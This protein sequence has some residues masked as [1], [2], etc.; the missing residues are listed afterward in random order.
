MTDPLF[1]V[2]DQV[3]VVSGGSRGI[4]KAI[5]AEF[6]RRDARVVISSRNVDTLAAAA[7][8]LSVGRHPVEFRVSDISD[9]EASERLIAEVV[10]S[11]G[12]IDT[13]VNVA[14]INIRKRAESYT[15]A[16]YDS[17]VNTNLRGLFFSAQAAGKR[18][19]AQNSGSIINI[20]SLNTN[21]PLRGVLPYAISKAGVSM[22]TRGLAAEW[23][24][25]GVRVNA[26]APGFILTDLTKKL[27]S[28]PTMQAW[29]RENTPLKRLGQ[30][31][32][33]TGTAIYLAS[34]ASRY[35]TGQVLYVDGG[36]S[37]GMRWPI[38]L[39]NTDHK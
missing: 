34:T 11:A 13:L 27:W 15:P 35:M 1:S 4:G 10:S 33:L 14:G 9:P 38:D 19:I 20:D 12:R 32:D 29:G 23:G 6:A 8:E 2:A 21:T 18:M 16:E 26:I 5:A 31:D 22:M 37:A 28:D 24:E 7:K 39:G 25:Y 3:V 30:V 17:I 36:I